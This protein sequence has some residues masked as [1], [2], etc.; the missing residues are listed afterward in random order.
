MSTYAAYD[1][2]EKYEVAIATLK[3]AQRFEMYLTTGKIVTGALLHLSSCSAHV[4]LDASAAERTFQTFDNKTVTIKAHTQSR[5]CTIALSTRV[6]ALNEF[7]DVHDYEKQ[8]I[9]TG[10]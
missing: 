9:S 4:S 3:R 8:S 7:I 2:A 6:V 1:E 5:E 10:K